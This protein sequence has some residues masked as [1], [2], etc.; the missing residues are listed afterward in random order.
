MSFCLSGLNCLKETQR[1]VVFVENLYSRYIWKDMLLDIFV[2]PL[3]P[4]VMMFF[5]HLLPVFLSDVPALS[6]RPQYLLVHYQLCV[7]GFYYLLT[8]SPVGGESQKWVQSTVEFK[9]AKL[10]FLSSPCVNL[11][12]VH[13]VNVFSTEVK[14]LG[15]PASELELQKPLEWERI[16]F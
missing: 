6:L 5:L 11:I 13:W 7:A 4:T 2:F 3:S 1:E 8:C 10:L 15:L 14:N 12:T 16:I 9:W